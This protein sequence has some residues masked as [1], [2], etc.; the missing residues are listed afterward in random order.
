MAKIV[1]KNGFLSIN[2]VDLSDH[3]E[4]VTINYTADV[5]E[6]TSMGDN[7]KTRLPGLKDWSIDVAFRQDFAASSVDKTLFDLVGAAAFP[8]E[9]RPDAGAVGAT[10][11]SYTGNALLSS[12]TP[13]GATVG[14][15]AGAPVTLVA[16]G[17]L[18]R[19]EA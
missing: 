9:A 14:D 18:V 2:S 16:D 8:I 17:D 6:K 12:Y 15:V 19:A 5:P 4:T 1:M 3:V 13:L 10:N 11:P 7:S